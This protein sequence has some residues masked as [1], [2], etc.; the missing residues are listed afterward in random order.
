MKKENFLNLGKRLSA[1]VVAAAIV[2]STA[3]VL[4]SFAAKESVDST[5][6]HA[7]GLIPDSKAVMKE[8]EASDEEVYD[9]D[10]I[11]S[12]DSATHDAL[13]NICKT[14]K[15]IGL[16]DK[17]DLSSKF[18]AVGD[19][20][21]QGSCSSWATVYYMKSYQEN[22]E[23]NWDMSDTRHIFSPS[24]TYNQFARGDNGKGTSIGATLDK[25]AKQ[26]VC[27]LYNMEYTRDDCSI[28]PN[29][30]Q[31]DMASNYKSQSNL[32]KSYSSW[33]S[34]TT[35]DQ[36]KQALANGLAVVVGVPINKDFDEM[37]PSNPVYDKYDA[38]AMTYEKWSDL[39]QW[40]QNNNDYY[41]GE[42]ALCLTGYDENYSYNGKTADVLKFVNS[43]GAEW[44]LDGY[45]YISCDVFESFYNGRIEAY[46]A[47]DISHDNEENFFTNKYSQVKTTKDIRA[48][49]SPDY[50]VASSNK[51]NYVKTIPSG[52]VID[53][54]EFVGCENNHQP[55]FITSEGYYINAQKDSLRAV[56]KES[57]FINGDKNN[58]V[59]EYNNSE[60]SNISISPNNNMK[61]NNH[62]T[63]K[64]DY[65][66]NRNDSYN[67]Y[68]GAKI[69][70]DKSI[71]INGSEG[72]SFKYMTP[73]GQNGTI[74]LCLQGSVAKKIVE[75][76]TTNG[77]W[78]NYTTTY[79][80]QNSNISDIELYI[81]GDES[82]CKTTLSKGTIYL[83]EMAVGADSTSNRTLTLNGDEGVTFS[84]D[85]SG[86]YVN[87]SYM[88][89]TANLDDH[90][91][92]EGWSKEK[93]GEIISHSRTYNF[94][95]TENTTLYANV[96]KIQTYNFS[97]V[98][99]NPEGGEILGV[100]G[101]F[102]V[103]S[104]IYVTAKVND[105]YEFMGWSKTADGPIIETSTSYHELIKNDFTLYAHFQ[106]ITVIKKELSVQGVDYKSGS[107]RINDKY[108]SRITVPI[109][110][111]VKLTAVPQECFHFEG[112]F[113]DANYSSTPISLEKEISIKVVDDMIIYPKFVRDDNTQYQLT[114]D[115][116][117][118]A[119]LYGDSSDKYY[120][121][122][123]M[124]VVCYAREGY[125][126]LGW[127]ETKG[128]PI[129]S[130]DEEYRF[131]ITKDTTLYAN[132]KKIVKYSVEVAKSRGCGGVDGTLGHNVYKGEFLEGEKI[133]LTVKP[134]PGYKF[135]GWYFSAYVH[136][137]P[138]LTDLSIN[139][140]VTSNMFLVPLFEKADENTYI[141]NLSSNEG[142]SIK[143]D[144]VIVCNCGDSITVSAEAKDHNYKFA[145]WYD[146][147]NYS[148]TPL[149]TDAI[150][151]FTP[152]KDI[153][154]YA[155]FEKAE[156]YLF[157]INYNSNGNVTS[158]IGTRFTQGVISGSCTSGTEVTVSA[159]ANNGYVF[160]GWYD[161]SSYDGKP[162]STSA[163]YT[164]TVNKVTN[165]YAKFVEKA[166]EYI[167]RVYFRTS[168]GT[169][170]YSQGNMY[171]QGTISGSC[172]EGT[173]I[174]VT[175][176]PNAGYK[177]V[178]WCDGSYDGTVL[179]T[180]STYTFTVN[181]ETNLYAKF[182]EKVP[183][184]IF[185]VYFRTFEGSVDYSLGTMYSQGTISGSCVEGTDIT[186]TAKP[187]VGYKFVGWCDGSYDGTVLSTSSTYT[188]TVNKETD[189][190]AKFAEE[191]V[192]D[193]SNIL[194]KGISNEISSWTNANSGSYLNITSG[195]SDYLFNGANTLKLDY[196]INTN[197]Q[198]G[199]YA[200]RTV[201]FESTYKNDNSKGYNGIGF[202]YMTPA[203]FN[204]QIALCLQSQ[205]A[206]LDD[207]VQL[208]ATNGEWKY[209]FDQT[210][211]T[212]LSDLTLYINGSKNGYTTTASNGTAKGTLYMANIEVAKK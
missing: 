25:I 169:V 61:Y 113:T 76:P 182:E 135:V 129:I 8:H 119:Y 201:S 141:V 162:L 35:I 98:N 146:N 44:G 199:G 55:Y 212:N 121:N 153:Y 126:F 5:Q 24:F 39:S 210:D 93:G 4:P 90:Y 38:K 16:P 144:S 207:L 188:F 100:A 84:G 175:A 140:T 138:A 82:N 69:N 159:K 196:N 14:A 20:N 65:T 80:F 56:V 79:N 89:V 30:S 86:T 209:Y 191:T 41:R 19:Q 52:T 64:I 116:D 78:T 50:F 59:S 7:T 124:R 203:D 193:D 147:S 27:S 111:E 115:G 58:N 18:P 51:D 176:K 198:Y 101:V 68:A 32:D 174:T 94:L 185:R 148:G 88:S 127:S 117:E 120:I 108:N 181:K 157:R 67:G 11:Q 37:K 211:K 54:K 6:L 92:F 184:H 173:D 145:G 109:N 133:T 15:I 114:V 70:A 31:F 155:K 156:E 149:S 143:G 125:E 71:E 46:I 36:I 183:E 131:K 137:K 60:S 72:I 150:Y 57:I 66:I 194:V 95:L 128:G 23:H 132:V 170:D 43:W 62:N 74:A 189:L 63:L 29:Q 97:Y 151:S 91:S 200:G 83:A 186:V 81:N 167:Y 134:L 21:P 172:V 142:G 179:S 26:G 202:W 130:T 187:N 75:L 161:N 204:G 12:N 190:Y 47:P 45:G 122:E 164:F 163:T 206:G 13:V 49:S 77:Q 195:S 17:V 99:L 154:L 105:G 166:S 136:G 10:F 103:N 9:L 152:D 139:L 192:S 110:T 118:G 40:E 171:K 2:F 197:D 104:M 158:S 3:S 28:Q 96:K 1:S 22:V 107:V 87:K 73:E 165:L 33:K 177:F 205:S 106:K 102:D 42:H 48:Y 85:L 168:E 180:S 34:L 123:N 112:W 178:G 53:I 208:P 160:A